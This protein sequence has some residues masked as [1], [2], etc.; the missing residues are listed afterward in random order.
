MNV[1]G[2]ALANWYRNRPVRGETR[3]P[4]EETLEAA[5]R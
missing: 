3:A 5:V 2:S 4:E 1:T